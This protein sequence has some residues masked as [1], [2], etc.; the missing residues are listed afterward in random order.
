MFKYEFVVNLPSSLSAKEFWKSVNI[1]GS[2]GQERVSCFFDSRCRYK[3]YTIHVHVSR[4]KHASTQRNC[5]RSRRLFK[6]RSHLMN[7]TEL[8]QSTQLHMVM[9]TAPVTWHRP[10]SVRRQSELQLIIISLN[11]RETR[12]LKRSFCNANTPTGIRVFRIN[13]PI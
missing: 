2:Y 7:W 12:H 1:W 9:R 13:L 6:P 5:L 8:N 10:T 4:R 11:Y 3:N